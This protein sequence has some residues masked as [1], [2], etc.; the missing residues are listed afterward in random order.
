MSATIAHSAGVLVTL[1]TEK[2]FLEDV[3]V[4]LYYVFSLYNTHT[5]TCTFG[6]V[7]VG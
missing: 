7:A 4:F 6:N 3:A 1:A 2:Q 5:H